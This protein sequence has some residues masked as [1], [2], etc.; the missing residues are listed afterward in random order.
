MKK[1]LVVGAHGRTGIATVK[2]LLKS[3]QFV[4][5]AGIRNKTQIAQFKN[6]GVETRFIDVRESVAKIKVQ[7]TGID[8]IVIALEGGWMVSLD[9]KVKVA[10]AAQQAGIKR[11]VLVSAGAIQH[12]HDEKIM[13]WMKE[14]EEYSAA[15]YYADMFVRN[16]S[17]DYT[18]VRPES[19]TD[20]PGTG[21]VN[22]GQD[23]SHTTVS[24]TDLARVIV[25]SLASD[26]TVRKAFDLQKGSTTIR[27]AVASV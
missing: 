1:I 13:S 14:M 15:L 4:P 21:L 9:G 17:L 18:I 10:Q 20:E 2:E 12:F 27:D 6:L 25:Q 5:I 24:R 11:L 3:P 19:L 8:A 7:L 26:N 16:S 23:L 22:I